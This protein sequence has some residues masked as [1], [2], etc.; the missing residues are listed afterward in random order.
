VFRSE[1]NPDS[2]GSGDK[3]F[4]FGSGLN[5]ESRVQVTSVSDSNWIRIRSVDPYQDLNS[6]FGIR[7]Q[8]GKNDP[9]KVEKN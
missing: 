7:I 3:C 4:R 9:T 6:G 8:E 5:P 2:R 1:L